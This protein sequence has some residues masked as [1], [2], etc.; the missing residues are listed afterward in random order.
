MTLKDK[1][2][3]AEIVTTTLNNRTVHNHE[4]V[5]SEEE[6]LKIKSMIKECIEKSMS[7][8]P[9]PNGMDKE[10]VIVLKSF[11]DVYGRTKKTITALIW[12]VVV[13]GF[14]AVIVTGIAEK[15]RR[16]F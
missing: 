16:F 1:Q 8:S 14:I 13:L 10:T 9:C 12:G 4:V 15:F 7:E 6:Y 11:S 3:I 2:D 5:F